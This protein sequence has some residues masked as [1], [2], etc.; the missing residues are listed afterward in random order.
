MIHHIFTFMLLERNELFSGD[1]IILSAPSRNTLPHGGVMDAASRV[2]HMVKNIG[3]LHGHSTCWMSLVRRQFGPVS[4]I[5]DRTRSM[6]EAPLSHCPSTSPTGG[7]LVLLHIKA[8][9]VTGSR[10]HLVVG[11]V[12]V[13]DSDLTFLSQTDV[14]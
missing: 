4:L 7:V 5:Q 10:V 1:I 12:P 9:L 13:P 3:S 8:H 11:S 14:N 2:L 6:V